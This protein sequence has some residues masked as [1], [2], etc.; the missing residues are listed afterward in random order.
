[1]KAG[2]NYAVFLDFLK[3]SNGS[4]LSITVDFVI[5][6]VSTFGRDGNL[7]IISN[8]TSSM[9]ARNARAPVFLFFAISTT[10]FKASSSK[11]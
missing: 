8:I 7:Y 9:I 5:V 3:V 6:Q 10:T 1:M 2:S 4:F 11:R